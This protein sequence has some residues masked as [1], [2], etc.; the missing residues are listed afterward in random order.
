MSLS[1]NSL[2]SFITVFWFSDTSFFPSFLLEILASLLLN[3]HLKHSQQEI[4]FFVF[5]LTI[6]SPLWDHQRYWQNDY[7]GWHNYYGGNL[8]TRRDKWDEALTICLTSPFPQGSPLWLCV[9]GL[10]WPCLCPVLFGENPFL[11]LGTLWI[12]LLSLFTSVLRWPWLCSV[13][14]CWQAMTNAWVLVGTPCVNFWCELLVGT[15][16]GNSCWGLLVGTPGVSS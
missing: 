10:K 13:L 8:V 12:F 2:F 1:V 3:S 4:L 6:V 11:N 15:S 5:H 14:F 16:G 7:M 9:F